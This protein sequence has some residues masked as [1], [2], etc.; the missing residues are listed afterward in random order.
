MSDVRIVTLYVVDPGGSAP[1]EEMCEEYLK[2]QGF[3]VVDEDALEE[4]DDV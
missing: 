2:R 4:D 3:E 1:L